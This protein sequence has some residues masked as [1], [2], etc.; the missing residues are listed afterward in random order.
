MKLLHVATIAGIVG[1]AAAM[2]AFGG[3]AAPPPACPPPA[4]PEAAAPPA[5]DPET[6]RVL[7]GMDAEGR[8]VTSLAAKFDYEL[9]Q[10]LFEDIKK[11]A[12]TVVFRMPND[13]KFEFTSGE[14]ETFVFDGRV[15]YH[16]KD[17]T[18]QLVIWEVRTPQEPPVESFELGKTPFPLPFGQKKE[19]VLK[20]FDVSRDKAEEAKDKAKRAVLALV[21]KEGT[22]IS[23]DYEKI[24]L[25]IETKTYLPTRVRLFDRSENITTIDFHHIDT[26]AKVD[27]KT[28][29]RPAVPADW[30]VVLH[31]KEPAG[32]EGK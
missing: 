16:K 12:G 24:V 28:F 26:K 30:E 2:S 10:T 4:A 3:E 14:K 13:F 31:P 15:L 23:R 22:A 9:N 8:K 32:A 21:P 18:K 29:A 1:L 5:L 19:T 11:R 6:D 20:Y 25:W 7:D 27:N 17:P